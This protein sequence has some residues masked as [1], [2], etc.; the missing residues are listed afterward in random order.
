MLVCLKC[1]KEMTC[2]KTGLRLHYVGGH[3]YS[4]DAFSCPSCGAAIAKGNNP[5]HADAKQLEAYRFFDELV[6]ML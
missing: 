6:E 4:V 5:H 3:C 1:K 2:T